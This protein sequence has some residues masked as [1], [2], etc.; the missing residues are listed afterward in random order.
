MCKRG[1]Y[2]IEQLSKVLALALLVLDF[3]RE[4]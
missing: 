3:C 4:R 1:R 2:L